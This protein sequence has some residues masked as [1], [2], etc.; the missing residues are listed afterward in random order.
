MSTGTRIAQLRAERQWSQT[1]LAQKV[2]I[3]VKS[4]KDWESD[5]SIPTAA[6]I[7]KLFFLFHTTSDYL[8]EIDDR[9]VVTLDRL[10]EREAI[11]ARK[12]FQL[13]IDTAPNYQD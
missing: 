6:S 4:V 12:L 11:R 2:G 10:S 9:P 7:K 5:V 13:F 8:L 3:N 1:A